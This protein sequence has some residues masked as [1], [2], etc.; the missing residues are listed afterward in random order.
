VTG[1]ASVVDT[2][3]QQGV[4]LGFELAGKTGGEMISSSG[5]TPGQGDQDVA[6]EGRS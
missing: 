5:T 1:K 6:I 3:L 4:G 2:V